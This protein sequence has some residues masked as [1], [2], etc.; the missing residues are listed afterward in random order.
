M[1]ANGFRNA[2]KAACAQV[3]QP[4]TLK[5]LAAA[6]NRHLKR[7]EAD[8]VLNE[9]RFFDSKKTGRR[10]S[11]GRMFYGAGAYYYRGPKLA[12][13]YVSY[14]HASN[15]TKAE[16]RVFLDALEAGTAFR[17]YEA[18]RDVDEGRSA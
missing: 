17:H 1:T 16:A 12:V 5:E 7:I 10:E 9:E 6:I 18:L 2:A 11:A 15:L 3:G 4:D 8:P 13:T 14:H